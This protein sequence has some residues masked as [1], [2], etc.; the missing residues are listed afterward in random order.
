MLGKYLDAVFLFILADEH[1][2]PELTG[3]TK[4]LAAPHQRIG[5]ARL[6]SGRDTVD[7]K[8]LLF[9]AGN[10]DEA[11]WL[12]R[13]RSAGPRNKSEARTQ[14]HRPRQIRAHSLLT[15]LFAILVSPRGASPQPPGPNARFKV[16]LYLIS[17]K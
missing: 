12:A 17:G 8:I 3:D 5:L 4:V 6:G 10:G 15:I 14:T 1:W 13:V 11:G 2:V 9:A 7:A 16:R